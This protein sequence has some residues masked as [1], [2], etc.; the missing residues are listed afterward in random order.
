MGVV[1]HFISNIE[2]RSIGE[3]ALTAH[4]DV[5]KE[6]LPGEIGEGVPITYV[7]ARNTIFLSFA[8]AWTE[9]LGVW[10]IFIGVNAF[11]L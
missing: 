11:D 5:P 9:V 3:S 2:L 1:E 7:P 4:I 8:L 10:D 6:R